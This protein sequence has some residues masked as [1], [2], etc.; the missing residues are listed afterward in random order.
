[1]SDMLLSFTCY[2]TTCNE[3]TFF[4]QENIRIDSNPCNKY[5]TMIAPPLSD[6]VIKPDFIT[7]YLNAFDDVYG[8]ASHDVCGPRTCTSDH[9]NVGWDNTA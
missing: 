6:V 2:S 5:N 1:M 9:A 3:N 4:K 7:K 8:G